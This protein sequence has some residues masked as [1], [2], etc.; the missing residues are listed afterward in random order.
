MNV[1]LRKGLCFVLKLVLSDGMV[2]MTAYCEDWK[3]ALKRSERFN[4]Y[5]TIRRL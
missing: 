3:T 1:P 5:G 2:S 4:T